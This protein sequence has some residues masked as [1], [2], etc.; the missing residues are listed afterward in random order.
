MW[1]TFM[2]SY[3][4]VQSLLNCNDS[5]MKRLTVRA[6]PDVNIK[7]ILSIRIFIFKP[8][9]VLNCLILVSTEEMEFSKI[10]LV[11]LHWSF[12]D[13]ISHFVV[14]LFSQTN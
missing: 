7:F 2:T 13:E 10:L 9:K 14:I 5:F 6:K 11:D 12:P 3:L 1:D 4:Y 8:G